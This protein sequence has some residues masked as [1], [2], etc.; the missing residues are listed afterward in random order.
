MYD[1]MFVHYLSN[2]I[3]YVTSN[4]TSTTGIVGIIF[5]GGKHNV[6]DVMYNML[7]CTL[8]QALRRAHRICGITYKSTYNIIFIRNVSKIRNVMR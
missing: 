3:S 6:S 8:H 2:V 1:V 5:E 4:V 7:R